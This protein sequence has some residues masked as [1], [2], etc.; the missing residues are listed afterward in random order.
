MTRGYASEKHNVDG[1]SASFVER[2]RK[3]KKLRIRIIK[4]INKSKSI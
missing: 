2:E 3:E 4:D 1:G